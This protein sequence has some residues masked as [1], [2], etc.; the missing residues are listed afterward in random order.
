MAQAILIALIAGLASALLAGLLTPHA[1]PALFLGVIAPV[2]ILLAGFGWHPLVGALAGIFC[3]LLVNLAIGSG[4]ALSVFALMALPAYGILWWSARAFGSYAGRPDRD[5]I[6]LGRLA[7]ALALYLAAVIV[8]ASFIAEPDFAQNQ[9]R[10]RAQF[11]ALARAMVA[12]GAG[13]KLDAQALGR[14]VDIVAAVA[15]SLG[16]L[17]GYITLVV[18]GTLAMMLAERLGRLPYARP[19]FRR[20]R[21][22]GGA[23][24]LLGLSFLLAMAAGYAGLFGEIVALLI[25][26]AFTLQGLAVIHVRTMAMPGR[27]IALTAMWAALIVF[28]FPAFLLAFL[29]MVDHLADFRRGR[30]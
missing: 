3:T 18:S 24:I 12:S 8:L 16:A 2:P 13:P 29:G 1:A 11:E 9:A 10:I 7:L 20:F 28:G 6:D 22:P 23:L 14:L 5:G 30:L 15:Q 27:A 21:L 25:F 4:V 19:D 26:A 17:A